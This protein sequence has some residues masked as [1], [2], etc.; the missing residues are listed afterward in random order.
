MFRNISKY[1]YTFKEVD[2]LIYIIK[3]ESLYTIYLFKIII[4]S[5]KNLYLTL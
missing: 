5:L 3:D 1:L 4:Y 2:T